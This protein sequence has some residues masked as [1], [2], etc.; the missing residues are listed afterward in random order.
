MPESPRAVPQTEQVCTNIHPSSCGSWPLS[1]CC[2]KQGMRRTNQDRKCC[3]SLQK[4]L[5]GYSVRPNWGYSRLLPSIFRRRHPA[6]AIT[7][8]GRSQRWWMIRSLSCTVR[9]PDIIHQERGNRIHRCRTVLCCEALME[10]KPGL[11]PMT[12][13]TACCRKIAFEVASCR[14]LIEP[15]LTNQTNRGWATKSIFIPLARLATTGLWP[16]IITACSVRMMQVVPGNT[17]RRRC[18]KTHSNTRL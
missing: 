11:S 17:F 2:S 18:E 9:F 14:C 7:W 15:S 13:E 3:S 16:L 10:A 4:R 1:A 5:L 6:T 8:A 12:S